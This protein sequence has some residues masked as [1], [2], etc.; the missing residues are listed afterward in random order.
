M[1]THVVLPALYAF[2]DNVTACTVLT[3]T[4]DIVILSCLD[5]PSLLFFAYSYFLFVKTSD[6]CEETMT[7]QSYLSICTMEDSVAMEESLG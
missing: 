6:L 5:L 1:Y 4:I 2:D 7:W 3:W